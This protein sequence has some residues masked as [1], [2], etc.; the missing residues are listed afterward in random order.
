MKIT[1]KKYAKALYDTVKDKKKDQVKSVLVEFIKL[2]NENNDL[3]KAEK[4]M[5][6]FNK[7]WNKEEEII[8]AEIIS[9]NELSKKTVKDLNDY[10]IELTKAK[11][12]EVVEKV[13]KDLLGGVVLKYNDK[14]ID[15]S[16]RT[17]LGALR[18]EIKK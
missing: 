2:L 4:I 5:S 12:V 15:G 16:V 6:E 18:K 9:A 13:D 14:I 8:E 11:N 17:K 3:T 7:I 1:E 10:I